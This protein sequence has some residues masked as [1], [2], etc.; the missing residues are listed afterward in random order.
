MSNVNFHDM[1][2]Y[3]LCNLE[4]QKISLHAFLGYQLRMKIRVDRN[5]LLSA[6]FRDMFVNV[7]T[8]VC[9][10]GTRLDVLF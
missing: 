3:H 6:D 4:L 7:A 8:L 10:Y 9:V 2:D 1:P 5:R